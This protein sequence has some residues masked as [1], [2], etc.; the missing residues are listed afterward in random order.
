MIS[1]CLSSSSCCFCILLGLQLELLNALLHVLVQVGDVIIVVDLLSL[2]QVHVAAFVV[3][4]ES[5][6]L[7]ADTVGFRTVR[8]HRQGQAGV[9]HHGPVSLLLHED[10][11]PLCDHHRR[12]AA[13]HHGLGELGDGHLQ[14]SV[15][16]SVVRLLLQL[17]L[18][19]HL[20][21]AELLAQ[22]L[23][24][25]RWRQLLLLFLG[26]ARLVVRELNGRRLLHGG[27]A[28]AHIDLPIVGEALDIFHLDDVIERLAPFHRDLLV[29]GVSHDDEGN[30]L[31]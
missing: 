14:L 19:I 24:R 4:E 20:R 5:A 8:V 28:D 27:H 3:S 7:A 30:A 11:G 6:G 22:D 1:G 26:H 17:P 12:D 13:E 9:S 21:V 10:L 2:R 16:E 18:L 29:L 15:L 31:L 25:R 23:R